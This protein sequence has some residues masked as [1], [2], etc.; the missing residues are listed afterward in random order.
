MQGFEATDLTDHEID[1]ITHLNAMRFF[2]F[3]PVL[4]PPAREVHRRR[5]P[6]RGGGPRRLDP[7]EGPAQ[8]ARQADDARRLLAHGVE[9]AWARGTTSGTTGRS[10][11]P[12]ATT[13]RPRTVRRSRAHRRR[14]ARSASPSPICRCSAT[15]AGATV[16]ELGCGAAQW[17][18]ALGARRCTRSRAR[19]VDRATRPR[20]QCGRRAAPRARERR[21]AAVRSGVVRHRV[22]RPRRDE[23]L[24]SRG[25]PARVRA[26]RC[27]PAG[28]SRSARRTR[29][30]TSRGT[31]RRSARRAACRSSTRSSAG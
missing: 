12:T 2:R 29:C 20:A 23:L 26:R 16:L 31:K 9:Q 6:G 22:L 24:R 14:G 11:T 27:A 13:T 4:D 19:R 3:D 10:G 25:H 8:H 17:S 1:E 28:C 21:A 7:V 18:I 30:C 5:A 15:C